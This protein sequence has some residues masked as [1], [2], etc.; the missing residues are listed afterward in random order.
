M[1]EI[2]PA[3]GA[4]LKTPIGTL[5]PPNLTPDPETGL[6][7]WTDVEFVNATMR[8]ISRGGQHLIPA[9]PY[10]SYAPHEG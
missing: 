6:A 8:G 4:P 9:F 5:Y 1:D 3:G 10:T 2:L 7:T